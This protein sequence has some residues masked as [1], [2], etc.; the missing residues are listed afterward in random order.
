MIFASVFI[1]Q[2]TN[3]ISLNNLPEEKQVLIRRVLQLFVD[4]NNK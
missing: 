2:E 3:V 4:E 1:I